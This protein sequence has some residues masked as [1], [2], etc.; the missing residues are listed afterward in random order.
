MSQNCFPLSMVFSLTSRNEASPVSIMEAMAMELP[1]VAPNVGSISDTVVHGETG[2]I[3]NT[4]NA[5]KISEC[6]TMLFEDAALRQRF[7]ARPG[8]DVITT[9]SS[10]D[11][12]VSGYESLIK[13]I[14]SRK[15][16]LAKSDTSLDSNN[17]FNSSCNSTDTVA[18]S[19]AI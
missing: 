15:A 4:G 10:L 14:Y 12:M 3:Y 6:W 13:E 1:V 5:E 7:W 18:S 16:G 9:Q 11:V 8:R 19:T 2:M 17:E